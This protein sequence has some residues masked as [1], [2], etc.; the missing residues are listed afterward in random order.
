[1]EVAD[2]VA[3]EAAD[4]EVEAREEESEEEDWAEP[5]EVSEEEP[6]DSVAAPVAELELVELAL[7]EEAGWAAKAEGE[8]SCRPRLACCF[9]GE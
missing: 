6:A 1:L 3:A 7:A 4:L 9:W 2:S 5:V 8:V